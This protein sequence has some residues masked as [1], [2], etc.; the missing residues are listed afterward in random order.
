MGLFAQ[1]LVFFLGG[2]GGFSWHLYVCHSD[3]GNWV[4]F[5]YL[6]M[7]G[8]DMVVILANARLDRCDAVTVLRM[9]DGG[10]G[11]VLLH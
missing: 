6:N 11:N 9:V 7:P 4:R 2:S 10:H 5:A 1:I 8:V 3:T